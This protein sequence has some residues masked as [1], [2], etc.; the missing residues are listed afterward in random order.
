[1]GTGSEPLQPRR[2]SELSAMHSA[3]KTAPRVTASVLNYNGRELLEAMLPTL[4]A[5]RYED[6][7]VVVIDDGSSDDTL[8][9]LRQH[10]PQVRVEANGENLGVAVSL[11]RAVQAA[12]GEYVALLNN[13]LELEPNWMSALVRALDEHPEAASAT[14]KLL[15]YHRRDR[16]EAAGDLMRWSGMSGHRGQDALDGTDYEEPAAVFSPCAGAAL[17]RRSTFDQIGFFDEEF[18]A[19]L[20]D[21]DWGY[22]AQLAGFTARYEPAAVAYHI[23]GATTGRQIGRFTALLRR[24]SLLIVI[25]NHPR[26][27]LIRHLPKVVGFQA[28]SLYASL[29][30]GILKAHLRELAGLR[31][32]LPSMLRKRAAIQRSRRV[33]RAQLEPIMEPELYAAATMGQRLRLLGKALAPLFRRG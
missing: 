6:F 15:D 10:W 29:R 32:I 20:E 31:R 23:G 21:V 3:A 5:Q 1:M 26:S 12:H 11:N 14:G 28:I 13:D 33:G 27:A 17:Y 2:A 18:F 8:E 16:L 19:Y 7:E 22:R 9:Y 24:N 30:D 4:L 25:K